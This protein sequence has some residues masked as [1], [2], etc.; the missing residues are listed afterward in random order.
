LNWLKNDE[1][2]SNNVKVLSMLYAGYSPEN[3]PYLARMMQS[4]KELAVKSIKER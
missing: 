2:K 3:E 4:L 1:D